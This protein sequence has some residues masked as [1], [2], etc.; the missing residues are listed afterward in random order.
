[1]GTQSTY[2]FEPMKDIGSLD[3]IMP[4]ENYEDLNDLFGDYFAK[5]PG[6]YWFLSILPE[7]YSME[8]IPA[9][10]HPILIYREDLG[11]L[12]RTS[13]FSSGHLQEDKI[14]AESPFPFTIRN[15]YVSAVLPQSKR[16]WKIRIPI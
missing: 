7:K 6:Q 12:V 9:M 15:Q 13:Q 8:P 11:L 10:V 4:K 1:M 3:P 16:L 14:W 2:F 5:C